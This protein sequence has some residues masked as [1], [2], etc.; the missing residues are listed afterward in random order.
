VRY[1]PLVLSG[2]RT[3]AAVSSAAI[4]AATACLDPLPD[5]TRCTG[6][7]EPFCE[8]GM[9]ATPPPPGPPGTPPLPSCELTAN[10]CL[11]AR[12]GCECTRSREC[13]R[14][15]ATCFPPPDCP[16]SIRAAA[17]NARCSDVR[18]TTLPPGPDACV[19]G[20]AS[21][22]ATCDGKGPMFQGAQTL[23]VDLDD[24]PNAGTL[25]LMM[26]VRGNGAINAIASLANGADLGMLGILDTTGTE[27]VEAV[28]MTVGASRYSWTDESGRP[29]RI[30]LVTAPN[31]RV[32]ID[33][34]VPF[35][36]P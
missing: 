28:S 15:A 30:R 21:C 13:E 10:E 36:L 25:G 31:S 22:A 2:R 7:A 16:P 23:L 11:A 19:C 8:A 27:V 6:M 17:P 24:L 18:A 32:E 1:P 29:Q 35:F 4:V 33:C 5:G 14:S 34:V 20:C 9:A 3:I 26:R 12:G